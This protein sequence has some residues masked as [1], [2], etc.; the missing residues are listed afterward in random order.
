MVISPDNYAS[1]S[2]ETWP[3]V[4]M[5]VLPG[6]QFYGKIPSMQFVSTLL[7]YIQV[8]LSVVLVGLILLQQSEGSLGNAF[9]GSDSGSSFH[10]KR[11]IEKTFFTITIVTAILFGLSAVLALFVY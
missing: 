5:S 4:K 3:P 2:I 7:P 8:V 10:K 6:K 9:G 11:G 1:Y